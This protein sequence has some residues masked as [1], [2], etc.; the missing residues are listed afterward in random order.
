MQFMLMFRETAEDFESR[1]SVLAD[2]KRE[3]GSFGV[4]VLQHD[5]TK[6]SIFGEAR[7]FE[8]VSL[9]RVAVGIAVRVEIDGAVQRWIGEVLVG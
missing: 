2:E 3:S 8:R 5:T 9:A 4:V 7:H 1:R 6:T